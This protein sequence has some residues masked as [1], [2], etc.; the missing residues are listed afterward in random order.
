MLK[1]SKEHLLPNLNM[2]FCF[3]H[4]LHT[5]EEQQAAHSFHSGAWINNFFS[6]TFCCW[7]TWVF[8][9]FCC[10][11]KKKKNPCRKTNFGSFAS[12]AWNRSELAPVLHTLEKNVFHPISMTEKRATNY[13]THILIYRFLFYFTYFLSKE[14]VHLFVGKWEGRKKALSF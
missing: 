10:L 11:E 7:A 5:S 9:V 1:F 3:I 6:N 13:T 8:Q 2:S 12:D 4:L 14:P